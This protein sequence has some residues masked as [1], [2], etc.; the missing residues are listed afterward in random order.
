M[1]SFPR[2]MLWVNP[3]CGLKTRGWPE[4]QAALRNMVAAAK[5][6]AGRRRIAGEDA[7]ARGRLNRKHSDP[8]S[9]NKKTAARRFQ[10]AAVAFW[11]QGLLLV[12]QKAGLVHIYLP[13]QAGSQ[14]HGTGQQTVT[15]TCLHTTTGTHRVTV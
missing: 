2:T 9:L 6:F 3:D 15:G 11:T 5:S 12:P 13:Q 4:V 7:M 14:Q 8:Q 1:E 10:W